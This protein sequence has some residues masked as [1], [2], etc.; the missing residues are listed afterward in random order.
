MMQVARGVILRGAG[1]P[2][3]WLNGVILFAMGVVLLL[4]AARKFSRMT[5]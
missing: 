1:L 3:L 4:V 2:E 5:V